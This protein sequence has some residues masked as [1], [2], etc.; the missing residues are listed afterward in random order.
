MMMASDLLIKG[1]FGTIAGRAACC[2]N[3]TVACRPVA[4]A[5]LAPQRDGLRGAVTVPWPASCPYHGKRES[6]RFIL[7][8]NVSRAMKRINDS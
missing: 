8:V 2:G 6:S 3:G 4:R 1:V 5:C 7:A